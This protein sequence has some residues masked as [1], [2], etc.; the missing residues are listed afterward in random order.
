MTAEECS[1]RIRA[2]LEGH[3]RGRSPGEHEDIFEAGFVNSLFA[4][5]LVEFVEGEFAVAIEE[6]DL[7]ID[8]FRT[9]ARIAS[10]VERKRAAAAA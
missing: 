5:E 10:L 1:E 7:H 8:H 3:F 4:L 9:V 6:D 2:F